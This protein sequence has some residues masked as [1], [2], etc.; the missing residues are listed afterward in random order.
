MTENWQNNPKFW[1]TEDFYSGKC[2]S[3]DIGS[4]KSEYLPVKKGAL[5]RD[6]VTTPGVLTTPSVDECYNG[7][8][9]AFAKL[10]GTKALAEWGRDNPT[11]FYKLFSRMLASRAAP[12]QVLS[13][14]LVFNMGGGMGRIIRGE[15][16]DE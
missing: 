6:I 1:Q 10:G 15:V 9:E 8:L 5:R 14:T 13:P 11:E 16:V 4:M 12:P 3:V 7:W 2:Q